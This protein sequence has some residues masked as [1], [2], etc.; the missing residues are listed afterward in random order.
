MIQIL[1]V[2]HQ[3]L[4]ARGIKKILADHAFSVTVA[5]NSD[6]QSI[7][8]LIDRYVPQVVLI[9]PVS[10]GKHGTAALQRLKANHRSIP[11]IAL[12]NSAQRDE[13]MVLLSAGA[14]GHVAKTA[15][16]AELL[17]GIDVT[18][19]G[20]AFFCRYTR[21]LL[22]DDPKE[23]DRDI[24]SFSEREK[25]I[26]QLIADG[27]SDKEIAEVLF[28]SYHTVRT[29]RKN[30]SKKVGFSLKNAAELV[31]LVQSLNS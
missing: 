21:S 2:D 22:F 17:N 20:Q 19:K 5:T 26:V 30:I 23:G 14:S 13:I 10:M 24:P 8:E 16:E 25:E 12:T 18:L 15:S 4:T 29:H 3:P 11:V 28:L 6:P 1:L 31:L 7:D 9:D 27:R